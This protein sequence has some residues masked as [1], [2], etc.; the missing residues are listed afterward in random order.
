[1][2]KETTEKNEN[3][4]KF[5][6]GSRNLKHFFTE[7]EKQ[8]IGADLARSTQKKM[9]LEDDKKAVVDQY[10]SKVSAAEFDIKEF[11]KMLNQ[12]YEFRDIDCEIIRDFVEKK[13]SFRR[14][15]IDEIVDTRDMLPYEL[16]MELDFTGEKDEKEDVEKDEKE[17]D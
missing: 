7:D 2:K 4:V 5:E 15:D 6:T 12:G 17:K 14:L 9:S 3:K 8:K 10:K 11:A 1:M 16:Q 13:I